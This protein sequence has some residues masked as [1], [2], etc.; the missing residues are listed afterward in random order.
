MVHHSITH[1]HLGLILHILVLN[2]LSRRELAILPHWVVSRQVVDVRSTRAVSLAHL[3]S[4]VCQALP[5]THLLSW[6]DLI[7]QLRLIIDASKLA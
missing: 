5:S 2:R 1:I 3:I 7:G 4:I 6:I